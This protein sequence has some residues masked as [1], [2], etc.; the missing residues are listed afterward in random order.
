MLKKIHDK[1]VSTFGKNYALCILS[2]CNGFM[3][4]FL[5]LDYKNSTMRKV[6]LVISL[7]LILYGVIWLIHSYRIAKNK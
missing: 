7:F 6:E 2:I 5:S 3:F 4:A 1:M